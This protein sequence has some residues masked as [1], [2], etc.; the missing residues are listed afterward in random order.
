MKTSSRKRSSQTRG[1]GLSGVKLAEDPQ[2]WGIVPMSVGYIFDA[3]DR[4]TINNTGSSDSSSNSN[5]KN[6][7]ANNLHDDGRNIKGY[8][9]KASFLEIYNNKLYDLID[10][11]QEPKLRFDVKQQVEVVTGISE[12]GVENLHMMLRLIAIATSNRATS[13]TDMNATSSRSHLILRLKVTIIKEDGTKVE[14]IGNF[15]DLA[16]SERQKKTH[17]KGDRFTGM[18]LYWLFVFYC[19]LFFFSFCY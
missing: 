10:T 8:T 11:N 9:V 1:R 18:F 2:H 15:A 5:N 3:L 13:G 14:G 19:F 4:R 17:A 12:I 7:L 16:G 6:P